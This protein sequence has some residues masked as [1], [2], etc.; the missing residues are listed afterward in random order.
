MNMYKKHL[1]IF[2]ILV[3]STILFANI[4]T[5]KIARAFP[6]DYF[7]TG[8]ILDSLCDENFFPSIVILG[9]SK[10][11]SGLDCN[12][13]DSLLSGENVYNLCSPSQTLAESFLYY[14]KLPASVHTVIQAIHIRDCVS[15]TLELKDPAY[16][17]FAMSDYI[18]SSDLYDLV[19]NE[20][21]ADLSETAL[22]K[23]YKCRTVLKSGLANV[24][25][26]CF[27]DDPPTDRMSSLKYPYPYLT[28]KSPNY[29]RDLKLYEKY[30]SDSET[31]F[32]LE[33][34]IE[35]ALEQAMQFLHSQNKRL[36]L[37]ISPVNTELSVSNQADENYAYEINEQFLDFQIINAYLSLCPADFYDMLHPNTIGAR[38]LSQE[39]ANYLKQNE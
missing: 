1:I 10:G 24:F 4:M 5:P 34:K 9:D 37:L 32:C 27:D 15:G 12:L 23:N 30:V 7:R 21:C 29:M 13:I 36:L 35:N 19:G 16:V 6:N 18:M 17:A 14:D 22:L 26:H 39:V 25:L 11:M 38:K 3:L 20:I 31:H 28:D 33:P 2:L 8:I